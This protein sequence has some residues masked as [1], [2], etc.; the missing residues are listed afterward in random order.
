M[1][2][3]LQLFDQEFHIHAIH[4]LEYV[5]PIPRYSCY[6]NDRPLQLFCI[7]GMFGSI[8]ESEGCRKLPGSKL[9]LQ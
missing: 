2:I 6:Y 8:C 7:Y 5:K 9:V 3:G 1:F 4:K